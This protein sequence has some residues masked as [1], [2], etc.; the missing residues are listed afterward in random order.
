[1]TCHPERS[2][3]KSKGLSPVRLILLPSNT[4]YHINSSAIGVSK[5]A[6]LH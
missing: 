2:E 1:M 4:M 6:L 3:A 5:Y